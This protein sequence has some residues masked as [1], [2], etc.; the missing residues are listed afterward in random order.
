[1]KAK[2]LAQRIETCLGLA[3]LSSCPRRQYGALIID[4][5]SNIVISEGYNG[6]LRGGTE[7]CGEHNCE[8]TALGIASGERVEIGC[9]HAEQNAIFNAARLGRAVLDAW[10][11]INGEPCLVCAKAIKQAGIARVIC[12]DG[13]YTLKAGVDL[14]RS[15]GVEVDEVDA[16][17]DLSLVIR[18]SAKLPVT[19]VQDIARS[20]FGG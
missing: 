2:H 13:G 18:S 17:A 8:R 19:P 15:N 12:V 10:I 11:I 5:R 4:P 14:L 3:R 20:R 6:G 16:S 9:V 7:L 1:M